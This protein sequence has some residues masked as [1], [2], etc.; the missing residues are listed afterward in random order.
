M[1]TVVRGALVTVLLASMAF[2]STVLRFNNWQLTKRADVILHGKCTKATPRDGKNGMVVT[3]YEFEVV[4]LLKGG[5]ATQKTLTFTALGGKLE[6]HG[7]T[8]SGSPTYSVGEE[9]ILFLDSVH[10]KTGCRTAIGLAQGKFAVKTEEGTSKKHLVRDLGGLRLVDK[11]GRL[12]GIQ[13]ADG[14]KLYLE[15]FLK[16]IKGYLQGGK[17][18]GSDKSDPGEKK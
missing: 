3:D 5:D 8:I 9:S 12:V 15:I 17:P 4:E 7:T 16:E 11:D 2:G 1:K 13:A 10:P 14:P 6:D 18:D